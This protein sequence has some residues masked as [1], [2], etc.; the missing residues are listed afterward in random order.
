MKVAIDSNHRFWEKNVTDWIMNPKSKLIFV[1]I[2]NRRK[3][4][5]LE[6]FNSKQ[7]LPEE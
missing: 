5:D 2:K 4:F 1:S 7:F 3:D 6:C